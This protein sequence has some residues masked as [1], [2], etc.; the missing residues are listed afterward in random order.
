ML[1]KSNVSQMQP[2]VDISAI[3]E[4]RGQSPEKKIFQE[5]KKKTFKPDYGCFVR[6]WLVDFHKKF[7]SPA[8]SQLSP[9]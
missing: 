5:P 6:D 9:L 4:E 1:G 2:P 3:N 8:E 7:M